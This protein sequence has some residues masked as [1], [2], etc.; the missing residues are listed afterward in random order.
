MRSSSQ[1]TLLR[2]LAQEKKYAHGIIR[3]HFS[4]FFLENEKDFAVSPLIKLPRIQK[5]GIGLP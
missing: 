5:G 1:Y 4:A 3:Q 2:A